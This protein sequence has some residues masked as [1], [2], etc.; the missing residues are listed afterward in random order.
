HMSTAPMTPKQATVYDSLRAF[1]Y[2]YVST[3]D[4]GVI[5]MERREELAESSRVLHRVALYP[6][7]TTYEVTPAGK[8]NKVNF[9]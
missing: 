8:Y 1:G 9:R 2:A 6:D 4:D 3:D 7:A 5:N